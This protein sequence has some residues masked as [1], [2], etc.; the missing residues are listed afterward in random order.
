MVKKEFSTSWKESKKPSKKRK[1]YFKAPLH[2]KTKFL[3]AHLSKELRKKYGF[4]SF[5][6]RKGDKVRV[7]RGSFRGH[8]GVV[9][10]VDHK[11]INVFVKG[12]EIT[13]KDGS[14]V[15]KPIHPSNLE[16]IELN[17]EDKK[18]IKKLESKINKQK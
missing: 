13:K 7:M 2:I 6:L 5:P 14:K 1:Y 11:K 3:S 9:E 18:R 8:V 16:I 4:R 15:I 12:V 10:R 17:L